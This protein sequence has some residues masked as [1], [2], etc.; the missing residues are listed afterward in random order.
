MSQQKCFVISGAPGSGKS[1][2]L[3]L[4]IEEEPFLFD[5][6]SIFLK[7]FFEREGIEENHIQKD[8]K[9]NKYPS[10]EFKNQELDWINN[11]YEVIKSNLLEND[12][13]VIIFDEFD[14]SEQPAETSLAIINRIFSLALDCFEAGKKIVLIIHE[15]SLDQSAKVNSLLQEYNLIQ[16]SSDIIQ[17]RYLNI[18]EQN[19]LLDQWNITGTEK[20]NFMDDMMGI[21]AA[22]LPILRNFNENGDINQLYHLAKQQ[23][24]KNYLAVKRAYSTHVVSLLKDFA[25]DCL[26]TDNTDASDLFF[27]GLIRMIDGNPIMP[28]FV[29]RVIQE[30]EN[31]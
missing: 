13:N 15:K 18:E 9:N 11:N 8:I 3:N 21:P 5:L 17:T 16:E 23:I 22:Y 31:N 28:P 19:F 25:F 29:K 1:E 4:S 14:L 12:S 20:R 24:Q 7:M 27:S 10:L 30:I 26:I 2:F 6:R